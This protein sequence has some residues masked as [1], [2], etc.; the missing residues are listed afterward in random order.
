ME[1]AVYELTA[2][3][4]LHDI[5]KL[6]YRTGRHSRRSHS[7]LGA[8]FCGK[9]VEN[10]AILDCISYHH[11]K[12]IEQASLD[13]GN[14]AYIVYIADN[15]S[16]G[17]DRREDEEETEKSFEK[18]R[19]LETIY[20]ILNNASGNLVYMAREISGEINYPV[21]R[22]PM[23]LSPVYESLLAGFE[24]GISKLPLEPSY[25]NSLLELCEAYF[26]YIPST[27]CSWLSDV[28]LFDHVKVT[29]SLAPCIYL[30]LSSNG[31][32]NF[33]EELFKR[34]RRFY[35][36]KAFMI[37]SL[38]ISGVQQFIYTI[39][40]KGALKG[41]RARSFYLE[42]LLENTVDE[43]LE[44]CS[45]SRANLIYSG[46]GRAYILLPNT[47][48]ALKS[49][50]MV[51]GSV[52]RALLGNFGDSLYIACGAEPCSAD[53]LMA[54]VGEPFHR[55]SGKIAKMKL[56]KYSPADIRALNSEEPADSGRECAVCGTSQKRLTVRDD[57]S[58]CVNCAA[59]ADIS[60]ELIR[61]QAVF[62]VANE[63]LSPKTL[64]LFSVSEELFLC[65]MTE[66][67]ARRALAE[68]PGKVVRLYSKNMFSTGLALSA[69]L[70]MGDY[71]ARKDDMIK[72]FEEL[73]KAATGARR[74]A[75]LR[76]DVDSLGSAFLKGFIRENETRA[77]KFATISRYATLSRSLSLFFKYYINI[78]LENPGYLLGEKNGP[79][80]AVVVYSGGDD[81]F[82]VGAWDDIL[83]LAVDLRRA[84]RRYTDNT[85]TL[86]AGVAFF[87]MKHPIS[88]M[89]EDAAALEDAAKRNVYA[90]GAKNSVSLFGMEFYKGRAEA[91]HTYD[92]DTF[93]KILNEKYGEIKKLQSA[94]EDYGSSFFHNILFL[95]READKEKINIARLAYLL[96]RNA[97]DSRAGKE[98]REAYAGFEK[99]LYSWAC[100]PEERRQAITALHIHIYMTRDSEEGDE[101]DQYERSL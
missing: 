61:P 48:Q 16:V 64:P 86:S 30:Y 82:I 58:M 23:E 70:W 4:L 92:W 40:S 11:K 87:K 44:S 99:K 100:D 97:P 46:G 20:N 18:N 62:V 91:R 41:L 72:T 24:N 98:A 84:F 6:L 57:F 45:L 54:K 89:A 56:R 15:I 59:F 3:A 33:R 1:N 88:L 35:K 47:G 27:T 60:R 29:A 14:L 38:D 73:S 65:P 63:R 93:E 95:L 96:A 90:G 69:K 78:I 22:E 9:Y 76:A 28:S 83:G 5:G 37:F 36:E 10:R 74:L 71:A 32:D 17:A 26:S 81:V 42:I 31:R 50:E 52:N 66:E 68:T 13:D 85:L 8:E 101:D 75:V 34:E 39:S 55:A 67:E 43:I 7:K 94:C 12:I 80:D 49:A 2:G 19:P 79:R 77:E 21:Q 53:E 25:I 51:I